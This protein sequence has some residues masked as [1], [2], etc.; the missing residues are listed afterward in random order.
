MN[1]NFRT[2]LKESLALFQPRGG[3]SLPHSDGW[4]VAVHM[5]EQTVV[6]KEPEP[7]A[8][9]ALFSLLRILDIQ[10]ETIIA[11]IRKANP[12]TIGRRYENTHP[13]KRKL[14]RTTWVFAHNGQLP[15]IE[16]ESLSWCQP[17][18]STD[19]ERAFC[20]LLEAIGREGDEKEHENAPVWLTEVLRVVTDSIAGYGEFNYIMSNG[21]SLFV[22]AHTYLH[23]LRRQCEC[24]TGGGRVSIVATQPLTPDE[25]WICLVPNSLLAFRQGEQIFS[26]RT[27]VAAPAEAWERQH[28]LAASMQCLS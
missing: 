25:P 16:R 1:A 3:G 28:R 20:L 14:G 5:G 4:G 6:V 10:G 8:S 12:S 19:S 17:A 22:H 2:D 24:A 7:A 13:F 23:H 21:E 15:G 18:G 11:H 9:S 26:A 27:R